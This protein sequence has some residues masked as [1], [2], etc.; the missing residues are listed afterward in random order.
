MVEWL[1][2]L[3]EDMR[4]DR[5]IRSAVPNLEEVGRLIAA[6]RQLRT[7]FDPSGIDGPT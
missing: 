6:L 4:I 5:E 7:S 3:N 1:L 2:N